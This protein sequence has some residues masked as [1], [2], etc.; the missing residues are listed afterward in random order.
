MK[1]GRRGCVGVPGFDR[2][3]GLEM[4]MGVAMPSALILCCIVGVAFD[5]AVRWGCGF[6][7]LIIGN[8]SGDNVS[9]VYVRPDPSI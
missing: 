1:S 5:S 7:V 9:G 8:C 4:A 6:D 3:I 2:L